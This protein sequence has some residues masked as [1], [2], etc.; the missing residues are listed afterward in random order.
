MV[1]VNAMYFKGLWEVPFRRQATLPGEFLL[2]SGKIT[3]AQFMQTRRYFKTGLDPDNA[4]K[5]IVVPFE[6]FF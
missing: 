5:V 2:G 4:A 6:V 1:L 3:Q